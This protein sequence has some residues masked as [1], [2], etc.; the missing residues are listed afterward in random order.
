MK[1][2]LSAL[3]LCGL[4]QAQTIS[5]EEYEPKSTL[6]VPQHPKT[7]AK[8]PFI[9]VHN[10]QAGCETKQCVDKLVSDMDSLNLRVMVNLSGGYG[11]RF[12]RNLDALKGR[13]PNRFVVFANIDFTRLDDPDYPARAEVTSLNTAY[14]AVRAQKDYKAMA[15]KE[16]TRILSGVKL[17]A[18]AGGVD[19]HTLHT[20]GGA[21]WEAIIAAAKKAKCDAIVMASHGRR[22]VSALL[23]GSETQRVLTHSKLPVLVVR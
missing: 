14:E 1:P 13:Y 4:A 9:D 8:Y 6:V 12:K 11:D 22:G 2:I 21:P 3:L 23:L 5:I 17:K 19:C 15:T 10:H 20:I 16:A 18:E 7:R